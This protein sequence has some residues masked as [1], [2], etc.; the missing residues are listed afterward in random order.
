MDNWDEVRTAFFVVREGTVSGAANAMGVHHATVIRHIDTLEER[1]GVKLFQRHARGYKPTD[2]GDDLAQ[3]ARTTEDQMSQ[4][5]SRLKGLGSEVSGELVITALPALSRSLVPIMASFREKYPAI[6]FKYM[7]GERLFRLEYGEAHVAI[8]AGSEPND[9]P[10]NVVQKLKDIELGLFG[11]PE[12]FATRA[13]DLPLDQH[14]FIGSAEENPRAPFRRWLNENVAED[15][16]VFRTDDLN[17]AIEAVNN[18]IGIGFSERDRAERS[19]WIELAS[20]QVR[21]C[22]QYWLVT[23]VDLHRTPKVQAFLEHL[24]EHTDEIRF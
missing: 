13:P 2:A 15:S 21:F 22:A 4:L 5:Q 10:D 19:G 11:S 14:A 18:G 24:K 8:R 17:A 12:Y 1:L 23:H 20:E 3:V 6:R 16:I 7:A 9:H